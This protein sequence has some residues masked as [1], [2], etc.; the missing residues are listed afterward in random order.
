[1]APTRGDGRRTPAAGPYLRTGPPASRRIRRPVLWLGGI[2]V[3][4]LLGMALLGE[5][6][7]L[8]YLGLRAER[9]RLEEDVS[10]L[11]AQRGGLEAGLSALD[12]ETGDPEA[13]ERVARERYRMRKPGE[14]V[15]EVV[16]EDELAAPPPLDE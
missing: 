10:E 1:M 3:V 9:L 4:V 2:A 7:L 6:G 11:H 16:G 12:E 15:I 14:T 5:N 8:T 13:L